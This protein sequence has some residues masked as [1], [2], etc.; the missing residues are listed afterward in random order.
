MQHGL[1]VLISKWWAIYMLSA[2]VLKEGSQEGE[3]S[4]PRDGGGER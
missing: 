1:E 3:E 4:R 2:A